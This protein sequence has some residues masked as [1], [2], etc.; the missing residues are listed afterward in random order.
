MAAAAPDL[1]GQVIVV[2]GASRGLGLATASLAAAAGGQVVAVVRTAESARELSD[3]SRGRIDVVVGD[4]ADPDCPSRVVERARARFGRLDGLVNNAGTV[5]PIGAFA[6]C[7]PAAWET[8]IGVDLLAP[9]RFCRA[10]LASRPEHGGRIVNISS[11]AAK[12]ALEGW[13]AYCTAKAGLALFTRCLQVD[14]GPQGIRA[15][16]VSPGV[17]DT[18]MQAEIR[19]SGINPVSRLARETLRPPAEPALGIVAL[20]AGNFDD[21]AGAEIDVRDPDFRARA[22]LPALA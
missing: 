4:V 15:F 13:S 14:H 7:D 22:C 16:S 8:A 6:A 21:L 18:A 10:F 19:A 12:S 2:T 1:A 9:V 17:I 11:G 5:Q 20:L 3:A